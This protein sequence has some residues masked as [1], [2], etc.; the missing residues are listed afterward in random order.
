MIEL[1]RSQDINLNNEELIL[2]LQ[3]IKNNGNLENLVKQGYQYSE[4][5]DFLSLATMKSYIVSTPKGITLSETGQA[6][7]DELNKKEKRQSSGVFISPQLEYKLDEKLDKYEVYLPDN[8]QNL[9]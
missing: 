7:L 6:L 1:R 3:I 4:I 8:T 2:F 5:A 9:M